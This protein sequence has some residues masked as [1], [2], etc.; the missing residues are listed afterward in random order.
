MANP[1]CGTCRFHVRETRD[2]ARPA[3]TGHCHGGPPSVLRYYSNTG[4]VELA[5]WPTTQV[6]EWCGQWQG[7]APPPRPS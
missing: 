3:L 7:T 5:V 6:D 1:C 4:L 2:P